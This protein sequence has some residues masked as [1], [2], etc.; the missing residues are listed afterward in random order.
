[1]S[2]TGSLAGADAAYRAAFRR[3]G[4]IAVDNLEQVYETAAFLAKAGKPKAP[5]VAILTSSGGAG[6]I[7]ADKAEKYNVALPQ[8]GAAAVAVLK[9]TI[10]EF[11]AARNPATSPPR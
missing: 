2:H 6:V 11:G 7:A 8:P 9:A 5:G 1:M 3:H 10:P 4:I